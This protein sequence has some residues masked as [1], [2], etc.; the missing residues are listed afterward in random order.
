MA[1]QS[2]EALFNDFAE[3]FAKDF[4]IPPLSARIAAYLQFDF[5]RDGLSFDELVRIFGVSKSSVS[6]ALQHLVEIGLLNVIQKDGHRK[7][8][9]ILNP[10]YA[11]IR[12]D[13]IVQRLRRELALCDRLQ[14]YQSDV[15]A[16]VAKKYQIYTQLLNSNIE[17]ISESLT[18]LNNEK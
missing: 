9:F 18:R 15:P 11:K 14:A 10:D 5:D 17:T 4:G 1:F 12:L 7:R 8:Y 2:D 13:G 3:F 16:P 6:T